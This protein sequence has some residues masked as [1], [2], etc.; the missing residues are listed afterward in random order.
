MTGKTTVCDE[1]PKLGVKYW[2]LNVKGR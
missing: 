2:V 1:A